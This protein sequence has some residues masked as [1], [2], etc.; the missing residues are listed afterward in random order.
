MG[1]WTLLKR[2]LHSFNPK[3]WDTAKECTE[4]FEYVAGGPKN[5][6]AQ[7][8]LQFDEEFRTQAAGNVILLNT[9]LKQCS[10]IDRSCCAHV[11]HCSCGAADHGLPCHSHVRQLARNQLL[12]RETTK[13]AATLFWHQ[14]V[15]MFLLCKIPTAADIAGIKALCLVP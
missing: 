4:Y 3:H 13:N 9:P 12:Y 1:S 5:Y 2:L 8:I 15:S 10:F 6:Y 14:L 11:C 7:A